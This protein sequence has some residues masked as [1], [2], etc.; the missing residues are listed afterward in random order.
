MSLY[1]VTTQYATFGLIEENDKI[2]Q[3][4]PIAK[5]TLNKSCKEVIDYYKRKGA[6]IYLVGTILSNETKELIEFYP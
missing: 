3:A 1:Q 2:I 5:W 4:A 6:A